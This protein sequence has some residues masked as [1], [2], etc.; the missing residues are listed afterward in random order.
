MRTTR[1]ERDCLQAI[2]S[3]QSLI[4]CALSAHP[5]QSIFFV[6]QEMKFPVVQK[7]TLSIQAR[8]LW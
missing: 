2:I 7:S 3:G 1:A 4:A 5:Q 8:V 6:R